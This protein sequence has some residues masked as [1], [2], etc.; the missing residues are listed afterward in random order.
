MLFKNL[1]TLHLKGVKVLCWTQEWVLLSYLE[2]NPVKEFKAL[3]LIKIWRC[4]KN[5]NDDG[6]ELDSKVR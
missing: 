4:Q 3:D 2:K 6:M 5:L 1:M